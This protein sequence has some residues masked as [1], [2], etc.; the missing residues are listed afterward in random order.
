MGSTP[1]ASVRNRAMSVYFTSD[2]HFGHKNIIKYCNR[3]FNNID[4]MNEAL[5]ARWNDVVTSKDEVYVLGDVAFMQPEIVDGILARLTG[6][7]YL[8]RGNHDKQSMMD[9][10][11]KRFLWVKDYYEISWQGQRIVLSHF[12][13]LTWN[14]SHHGSWHLHGH[15]HGSLPDDPRVRRL[16]VGVDCHGYAP[17]SFEKVKELMSKKVFKPIDHHDESNA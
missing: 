7:K 16:D 12:P 11:S 1:T 3:P 8:I 5:I 15:C 10:Y 6:K 9:V 17:I 2:H 14:K 13:F 4:E